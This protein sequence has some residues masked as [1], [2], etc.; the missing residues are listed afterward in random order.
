[1]AEPFRAMF[2]TRPMC[3]SREASAAFPLPGKDNMSHALTNRVLPRSTR[4][5]EWMNRWDCELMDELVGEL[6]GELMDEWVN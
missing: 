3:P 6:V 2:V 1:M 5:G 4:D